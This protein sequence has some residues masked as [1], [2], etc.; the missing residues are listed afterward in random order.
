MKEPKTRAFSSPE[1]EKFY[2]ATLGFV[3]IEIYNVIKGTVSLDQVASFL[4]LNV[5]FLL[6]LIR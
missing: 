3:W 6:R 5:F 2:K 4:S 1:F